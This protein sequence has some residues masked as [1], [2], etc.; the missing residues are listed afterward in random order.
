MS[1]R[2]LEKYIDQAMGNEEA[3]L[4]IK[5]V[6]LLNVADGSMDVTDIAI[7]EGRIVGTYEN[8]KGREEIDGTDLYAVPGFIDSHVHVESSLITPLEFDRCVLVRGTTTAICDP[9][10]ISNVLGEEALKYFLES[11]EQTVMD[12]I[13]QLSSCV[14]ATN[15]ETSGATLTA[16]N[17]LKFKDH[18]NTLGLAEFM[19]IGG[20]LN[21]DPDVLAKLDAFSDRHI[22]GHMPGVRGNAINALASCG[23]RNCHESTD[24]EQAEE[25]LKK[26]IIVLI[27]EG[28]VCKDLLTLVDLIEPYKSAR[29]GFCTDDRNPMDIEDEG[30]IDHLIRTSIAEGADLASV[31]RVASLSAAE[32]FGLRDR[33]LIAPGYNAD[34][35]LL[36]D[37]ENCTIHSVIKSG[38]LVTPESFEARGYVEPVGYNSVKIK[39]VSPQDFIF[40]SDNQEQNVI[41]LIKDQ[42]VT[43]KLSEN[44]PCN[45]NGEIEADI[46]QD[47]MKLAVL[48]RHGKNGNIGRGF[49][50]GFGIKNGT[51]AATFGH[52]SHNITVVGTSDDDMALAVNRLYEIQGGFVVVQDGKIKAELSLP[53]AGLMS[54]KPFEDVSRGLKELK[55]AV[56]SL[57]SEVSEPLLHMIFLPLCVIPALK[58]TDFGLVRFEPFSGDLG[59]V[60][61]DDQRGAPTA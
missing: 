42:I 32:S 5:N 14:P 23:I 31:Y 48:E 54:D 17:L 53:I 55:L 34:I 24:I 7:C 39:K 52:D 15:L 9:H 61:I 56:D 26:G 60:L 40:R 49:V 21:K 18:S 35:V 58:L 20:V 22:D 51:I 27:R 59:P 6:S 8:Y 28:T 50:K 37:I 47:I 44:M 41:G 43:Q 13:V 29:L 11:S 57:D 33:G 38:K 45:D 30:H 19:D 25:K 46:S 36:S 1:V 4:V 10:E 12:L 16:E 2:K 3:D